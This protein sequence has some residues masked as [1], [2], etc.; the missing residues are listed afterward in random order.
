MELI[1]FCKDRCKRPEANRKIESQVEK[2]QAVVGAHKIKRSLQN[3]FAFFVYQTLIRE[4]RK[5]NVV[6]LIVKLKAIADPA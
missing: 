4:D 2:S 5:K 6:W 1:R 3:S